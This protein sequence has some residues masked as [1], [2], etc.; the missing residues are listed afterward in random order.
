MCVSHAGCT[1]MARSLSDVLLDRTQAFTLRRSGGVAP[2][3]AVSRL[4]R[5]MDSSGGLA[6]LQGRTRSFRAMPRLSVSA[7]AH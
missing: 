1:I 3:E 7:T 2:G 6:K 4:L 5:A